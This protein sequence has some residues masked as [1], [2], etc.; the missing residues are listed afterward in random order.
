MLL[1]ANYLDPAIRN[2]FGLGNRTKVDPSKSY[3]YYRSRFKS[4]EMEALFRQRFYEKFHVM[5]GPYFFQYTNQ[6]KYNSGNV[7]AKPRQV[8]LDSLDIFSRKSY[9]GGKF[10]LHVDNRNSDLFPTRGVHWDNEFLSVFGLTKGSDNFSKLTSDMSI[11][12]SQGDPAKLITVV[13]LGG[14]HIFSKDYEYFQALDIGPKDQLHGF[15]KNRYAGTSNAYASLELRIKLMQVNSYIL[16]GPLG[17]TLF[18]DVGRVWLR[19]RESSRTWHT[20][21]GGGFYYIPFNQF[22]V[23]ASVGIS[24]KYKLLNF[25]FGTKIGLTF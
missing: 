17:L 4:F 5:L 2:F 14:G 9:L 18:S 11:F 24:G 7:L 12:I 21:F 8:G 25:Y 10:A 16:P 20:A 13:T 22:L 23:S 15:R 3:D 6:Y 1:Q 19:N